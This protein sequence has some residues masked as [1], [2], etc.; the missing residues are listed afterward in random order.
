MKRT[1][2]F[3]SKRANASQRRKVAW[4]A[5][6][7]AA[8][9][10]G[11]AV[12]TLV[13]KT[14]PVTARAARHAA[15]SSAVS[16]TAKAAAV[17]S[18]AS[19]TGAALAKASLPVT[20]VSLVAAVKPIWVDVRLSTQTVVVYDAQNRVVTSF[21]CSSG[22]AGDDTPKGTF[23]VSAWGGYAERGTSFYSA[24][25][26]EGA[27]Y[28][29]RFNKHI[30]FHSVPYDKNGNIIQSQADDLGTPS[31]HGC[32]HLSIDDAKWIYQNIPSGTKVVV[33]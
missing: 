15:V 23:T 16:G 29:V 1:F 33:E 7:A 30:L 21:I 25:Y 8:A 32:I 22:A 20:Q 17:S 6:P 12:C 28:Y 27:Y 4:L 11:I 19:L 13:L 26:A 10:V 31:S 2:R 9:C 14:Q 5:I 24:E 3:S 18:S